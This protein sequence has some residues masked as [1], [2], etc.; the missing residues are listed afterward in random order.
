MI[1]DKELFALRKT[2]EH[3]HESW[4]M[5]PE[6]NQETAPVWVDECVM[7][8]VVAGREKAVHLQQEYGGEM[9]PVEFL[10]AEIKNWMMD[11]KKLVE[12]QRKNEA[13]MFEPQYATEHV[14]QETLVQT[15][16]LIE[17]CPVKDLINDN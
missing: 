12:F 8:C 17:R 5:I 4:C 14:L 10:S 15:H 7:A 11:L 1:I 2:D 9:V 13:I 16:E 6:D 3:G